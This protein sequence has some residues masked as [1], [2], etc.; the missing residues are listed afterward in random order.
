M[1]TTP[2]PLP[3]PTTKPKSKWPH[4]LILGF[5]VPLIL[6]GT[7]AFLFLPSPHAQASS[8]QSTM[9]ASMSA[10]GVSVDAMTAE[11]VRAACVQSGAVTV[12]VIAEF[13]GSKQVVTVQC[14]GGESVSDAAVRTYAPTVAK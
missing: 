1:T 13:Q 6:G 2:T 11:R 8:S 4:P 7:Y 3:E 10:H 9:Q 5:F 14:G 12:D